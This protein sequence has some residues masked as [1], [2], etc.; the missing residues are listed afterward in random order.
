MRKIILSFALLFYILTMNAQV[1]I[2]SG[3]QPNNDA[4]L[5]LKEDANGTAKKGLLMPRV[6]LTAANLPAPMASHTAGMTVYNLATSPTGTAQEHYVSPGFYYNTG[7]RWERLNMGATNWFYM[8]SVAFKTDK[9]A[10][11]ETKDLYTLYKEQFASPVKASAGAPVGVP[12]IP[13][14]DQLYYYVTYADPAVFTIKSISNTG[15]MNYDV[16]ASATESSYIN[17]VFVLK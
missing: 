10:T 15:I 6:S 3:I 9:D 4:L 1:T 7:N 14:A 8:P 11:G 12:Y 2:G 13:A 16:R 5:D 17:V